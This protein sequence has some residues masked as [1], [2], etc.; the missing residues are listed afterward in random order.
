MCF[1]TVKVN[2]IS[3]KREDSD[4]DEQDIDDNIFLGTLIAEQ[5][6]DNCI[7]PNQVGTLSTRDNNKVLI[8]TYL[9]AKPYD[10][11]TTPVVC[12]IDT[13]GECHVCDMTMN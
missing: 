6:P 1:K 11:P 13:G 3:L 12:K 2:C 7:D 9:A 10:K 8:Q 5:C 4:S